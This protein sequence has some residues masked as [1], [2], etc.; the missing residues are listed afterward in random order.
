MHCTKARHASSSC[1][2]YVMDDLT[3]FQSHTQLQVYRLHIPRDESDQLSRDS[4]VKA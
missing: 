2:D 1:G 4:E 3:V